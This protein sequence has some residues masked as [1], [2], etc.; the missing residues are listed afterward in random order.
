MRWSMASRCK[1]EQR[2]RW[3]PL[4]D[5]ART[6]FQARKCRSTWRLTSLAA[7]GALIASEEGWGTIP[8]GRRRKERT[9]RSSALRSRLRIPE[10]ESPW[11]SGRSGDQPDLHRRCYG[12]TL[13]MAMLHH[14]SHFW[15]ATS[16]PFSLLPK[17][18]GVWGEKQSSPL[19]EGSVNIVQGLMRTFKGSTE[20]NLRTETG[21]SHPPIPWIVEHAAQLKNRYMVGAD[22]RIPTE[23]LW[24]RGVQRLVCETTRRCNS[25]M[26]RRDGT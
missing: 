13:A 6:S 21:P 9:Q 22:G 2:K 20:S 5:R 10:G 4:P 24:G 23:R 7:L 11:W 19:A 12:F 3:D 14:G 16:Q 18:F 8:Q 1:R 25:S 26:L 17:R 15:S